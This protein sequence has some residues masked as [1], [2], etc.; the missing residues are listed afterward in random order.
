MAAQAAEVERLMKARADHWRTLAYPFGSEMA[1]DST[2]QPEVYAWM[3]HFGHRREAAV[4]REVILGYDPTVPHWG[5]NG[6]ARRYWDFLYGGKVKRIE[7]QLHHYGSA[8]NAV[9]L[10]D[11]YRRDPGDLHLLRVAYGGFM[12]GITNVDRDGFAS[13]AFHSEPD[14]MR[15][16]AYSG[17]Y[18]MGYF[19]HAYAAATYLLKDATFGWLG[20]GGTV[21]RERTA[22]VIVPRDGAR[23]RLFVAPAG[24]WITLAAGKIARARWI[25]AA[26]R[27]EVT[28]DPATPAT[29]VAR[30]SV[31]A[32]AGGAAYAVDR[33]TAE[34]G[35]TSIP[36]SPNAT[37]VTL[38]PR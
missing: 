12:G 10:F 22:I 18:G 38:T 24:Q 20:F 33:G 2:G 3:Q 31:E 34:R 15:W 29:P 14:M 8:L 16:D 5:Y 36:L 21:T 7:R 9:P 17:D 23:T 25:P 28:L 35:F 13:A 37:T 11:A 4:T 19:G 27:I 30:L 26:R 32:P 1:W 6:N